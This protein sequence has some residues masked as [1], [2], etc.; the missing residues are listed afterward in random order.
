MKKSSTPKFTTNTSF[1]PSMCIHRSIF[2][3][4][5]EKSMLG[6]F[7]STGKIFFHDFRFSFPLESSFPRRIPG[8]ALI[9]FVSQCAF[10]P[11]QWL[12]RLQFP[13]G[14]QAVWQTTLSARHAI[15]SPCHAQSRSAEYKDFYFSYFIIIIILVIIIIFFFSFFFLLLPLSLLI[16]CICVPLCLSVCLSVCLPLPPSP[17]FF[18]S[19]SLSL[20]PSLPPSPLPTVV[21]PNPRAISLHIHDYP[22]DSSR[23]L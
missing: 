2:F 18:Y 7:F 16:L 6:D 1:V 23:H 20:S 19:L 12:K 13:R 3:I 21:F 22:Q 17:F 11:R 9:T 10:S 8:S 5:I 15:T 4:F 14:V